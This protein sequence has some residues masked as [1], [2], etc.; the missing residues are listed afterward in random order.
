MANLVAQSACPGLD[1]QSERPMKNVAGVSFD[2]LDPRY[3]TDPYPILRELR[4]RCPIFFNDTLRSWVLT[5]YDDCR[6]VVEDADRFATDRRK[7]GED[8]ADV[9]SNVQTIDPPEHTELRRVLHVLLRTVDRDAME[10]NAL[11]WTQNLIDRWRDAGQVD[12]IADY[13]L[14]L[15]TSTTAFLL[16]IDEDQDADLASATADIIAS[17]MSAFV[18]GALERGAA[19]RQRVSQRLDAWYRQAAL[20]TPLGQLRSAA[21]QSRIP[22]EQIVNSLRVLYLAGINST[23][24]FLGNALL[25]MIAEPG[26]L[27][28]FA[29]MRTVEAT[30]CALDE[31][32]RYDPSVQAMERVCVVDTDIAGRRVRRGQTVTILIGAANRD[33]RR[34]ASPDQ[35]QLTRRPNPHLSFGRGP[36]TCMGIGILASQISASLRLVAQTFPET[37]VAGSP[38]RENN[39]T[40]RGL[41]KLPITLG[42]ARAAREEVRP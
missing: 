15:A 31:L 23:H 33:P 42:A 16:G 36:H 24:R 13:T 12:A 28:A 19:A 39:P 4:E 30:R 20:G 2:P 29:E 37:S 26:A 34:F 7:V 25:A 6:A 18:D 8:V 41:A 40:L 17:M 1:W 32:L 35:L 14:P 3:I 5:R 22:Q 9:V 38:V 21:A 11:H 27:A 10:R